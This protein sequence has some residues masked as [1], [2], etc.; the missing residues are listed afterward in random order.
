LQFYTSGTRNK[1]AN[2]RLQRRVRR[3][4]QSSKQA[5]A[6]VMYLPFISLLVAATFAA[7]AWR[8]RSEFGARPYFHWFVYLHLAAV[9]LHQFEE[10]GW[11]GNF[12]NAFVG[13]FGT[14]QAASLVPPE[15][16]LELL[17][18]FG[19]TVLFGIL[20]LLGTRVIWLGLAL[21][22][23]NFGNGFF[24][25]IYSVTQMTYM[26]GAITGT[27]LYL[28][29]GL[30]ATKYAVAHGHISDRTL[31]PAFALGTAAS[32]LP[33]IHVWLLHWRP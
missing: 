23:V 30:S 15:A 16:T 9:G 28:P 1:G 22:F 26:P 7:I 21:L 17:N 20:G 3:V 4:S 31:L 18:V 8:K 32:F 2:L 11:P 6:A 13:V 25:L 24:H 12:R 14:K 5:G 33:F 10:Y 29:L 19:F 27:F